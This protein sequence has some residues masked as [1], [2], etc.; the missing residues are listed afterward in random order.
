M[1][2]MND[3]LAELYLARKITVGDALAR[4]SNPT[5]LNEMLSRKTAGIVV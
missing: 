2:T 3:S 1:R 4:S 5:E